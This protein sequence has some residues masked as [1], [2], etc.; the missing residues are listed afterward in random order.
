MSAQPGR[1]MAERAD[2]QVRA[3]TTRNGETY[4]CLETQRDR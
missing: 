1:L 4:C 2:A 3:H